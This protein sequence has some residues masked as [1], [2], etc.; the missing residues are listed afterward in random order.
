MLNRMAVSP[1]HQR[2][3]Y[4]QCKN[5]KYHCKNNDHH[6]NFRRSAASAFRSAEHNS[7]S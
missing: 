6:H 5:N 4:T 3:N 7:P 2:E 1:N